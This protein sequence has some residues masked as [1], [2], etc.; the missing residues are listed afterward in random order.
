MADLE[1]GNGATA[2]GSP[3]GFRLTE[4]EK[5]QLRQSISD[6]LHSFQSDSNLI[7]R[8]LDSPYRYLQEYHSVSIL[9]DMDMKMPALVISFDR[10]VR[11]L[12]LE[13]LSLG[14]NCLACIL[15]A[16]ALIYAFLLHV[17]LGAELLKSVIADVV[18][19]LADFFKVNERIAGILEVIG[20]LATTIT[21]L[22][23]ARNFCRRMGLCKK[24]LTKIDVDTLQSLI[25]EK[26][27][28]EGSPDW[29]EINRKG[30]SFD[31]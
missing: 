17:G 23:L 16:L 18:V 26:S 19:V 3:E 7:Y 8:F 14:G 10:A 27:G 21:P 6:L 22:G 11:R 29:I 4:A 9:T 1:T 13:L 30:R 24:V 28:S 15:S 20:G 12:K 2:Q 25:R 5:E 31:L